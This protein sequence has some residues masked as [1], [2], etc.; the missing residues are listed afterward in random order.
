VS[1][2]VPDAPEFAALVGRAASRAAELW[3]AHEG[4]G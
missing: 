1:F 4:L 2:P 3:R